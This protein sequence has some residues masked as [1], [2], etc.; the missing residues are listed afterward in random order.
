MGIKRKAQKPEIGDHVVMTQ[1]N[2]KE[3]IFKVM[4]ILTTTRKSTGEKKVRLEVKLINAEGC[5]MEIDADKIT[6][7]IKEE[8]IWDLT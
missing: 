2:G 4:D 8:R 3:H 6:R 7:V 5:T 1:P